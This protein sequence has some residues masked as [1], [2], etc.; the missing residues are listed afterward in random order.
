MLRTLHR[1]LLLDVLEVVGMLRVERDTWL[2]ERHI[3]LCVVYTRWV[4]KSCRRL[5]MVTVFV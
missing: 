4:G 1:K 3:G 5:R 2:A